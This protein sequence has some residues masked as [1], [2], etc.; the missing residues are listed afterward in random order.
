METR[1]AVSSR[2][3]KRK[4]ITEAG[5]GRHYKMGQRKQRTHSRGTVSWCSDTFLKIR[6]QS[7]NLVSVRRALSPPS[8]LPT[9]PP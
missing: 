3:G 6:L 7:F 9:P 5:E 8:S 1:K 2:M 4:E